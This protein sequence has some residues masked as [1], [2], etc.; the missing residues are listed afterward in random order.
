MAKKTKNVAYV[1]FRGRKPGIYR[2]WIEC[3]EQVTKYPKAVHKGFESSAQAEQTWTEWQKKIAVK[4]ESA[5]PPA[6]P[7]RPWAESLHSPTVWIDPPTP[8]PKPPE[9]RRSAEDV[10]SSSPGPSQLPS[11]QLYYFE[12][13]APPSNTPPQDQQARSSLEMAPDNRLARLTSRSN[14][15]PHSPSQ[16][17]WNQPSSPIDLT[18]S[19]PPHQNYVPNLK[20]SSSFVD[21]TSDHED[22]ERNLKIF[23]AEVT[24]EERHEVNQTDHPESHAQIEE[25]R[26]ELS[27]EQENVV[28]LALRKNN[29]FLTGAAGCGKTVTLKEILARFKKRKKG[30]NVQVIAPTGIAALP[31]DGRT[32]Y[33]FAGVCKCPLVDC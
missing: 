6:N 20:R 2:T 3:E 14:T 28:N 19:S 30:G 21:L 12:P 23:K 27:P 1:V 5:K 7:S 10:Q 11:S 25:S 4:L 13:S 32:T 22:G 8:A 17:P 31:L 15:P 9:L 26:I 24:A 18:T 16:N 33:S 29:I